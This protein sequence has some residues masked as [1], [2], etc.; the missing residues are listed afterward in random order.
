MGFRNPLT[1][2][3]ALDTG[4]GAQRVVIT[5]AGDKLGGGQVLLYPSSNRAAVLAAGSDETSDLVSL[6][7]PPSTTAPGAQLV[8]RGPGRGPDAGGFRF[9]GGPLGLPTM[10]AAQRQAITSWSAG[11]VVVESDTGRIVWT[12]DAVTWRLLTPAQLGTA[13]AVNNG[14]ASTGT[15]TAGFVWVPGLGAQLTVPA[16]GIRRDFGATCSTDVT[17]TSG[18]WWRYRVDLAA[19]NGKPAST[20]YFPGATGFHM[21]WTAEASFTLQAAGTLLG[22]QAAALYLEG[23]ADTSGGPN[24]IA[25]SVRLLLT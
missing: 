9:T 10:T 5:T 16:D 7:A 19:G 21:T 3:A 13:G 11:S 17:G 22:D 2:A 1:R 6:T 15:G 23:R 12:P 24:I 20:S 14:W 25:P 8:M 18:A 4:K